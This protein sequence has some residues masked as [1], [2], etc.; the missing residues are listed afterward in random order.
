MPVASSVANRSPEG[1]DDEVASTRV[2]H[3]AAAQLDHGRCIAG[4]INRR[5]DV[6][7]AVPVRT[8]ERPHR[9]GCPGQGEILV[10]EEKR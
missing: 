4:L 7:S 2:D 3:P 5:D 6:V 1:S 9:E 8:I 10:T